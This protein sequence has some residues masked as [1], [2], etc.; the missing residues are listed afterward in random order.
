MTG[1]SESP[2]ASRHSTSACTCGTPKLVVTRWCSRPGADANL[3]AVDAALEQKAGAIRRRDV[4]GNHSHVAE[5]LP[6]LRDRPI[7]HDRMAM[8]NVDDDDIDLRA[9]EFRGPLG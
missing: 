6:E 8:G 2:A 4:A 9:N 5:F 7:H 1:T 3:D